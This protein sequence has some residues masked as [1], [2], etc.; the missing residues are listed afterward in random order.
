MN[1]WS[2][3]IPGPGAVPTVP[4]AI[5][6]LFPPTYFPDSQRHSLLLEA[7]QDGSPLLLGHI[8]WSHRFSE[9]LPRLC[10]ARLLR[11]TPLN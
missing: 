7:A 8:Y 9:V 3:K 11:D 1:L 5:S 4:V 6:A 10:E 2:L